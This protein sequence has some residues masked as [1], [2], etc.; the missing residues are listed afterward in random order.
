MTVRNFFTAPILP[1]TVAK[2]LHAAQ[3]E[4]EREVVMHIQ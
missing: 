4:C 3:A 2:K 1:V